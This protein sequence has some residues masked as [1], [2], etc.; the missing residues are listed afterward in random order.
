MSL[1]K[2]K[3]AVEELRRQLAVAE[4]NLARAEQVRLDE[5]GPGSKVYITAKFPGESKVYEYLALRTDNPRNG[6]ANWYCTGRAG[7]ITWD[8]L[9]VRIE[10]AD[11]RIHT[12]LMLG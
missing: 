11:Y 12:I 7:K 3:Q 6:G 8:E 4:E 2:K 1:D 10:R 9:L 5:P